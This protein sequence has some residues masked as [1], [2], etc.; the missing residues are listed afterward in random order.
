M[1]A[2]EFTTVTCATQTL[3]GGTATPSIAS[4]CATGSATVAAT[5]YTFGQGTT[6]QWESATDAAFTTGVAAIGTA[7]ANYADLATGTLSA[8]TYYRLKVICNGGA[9]AYSTV[10]GVIKN[11]PA[12]TTA[13][14]TATICAGASTSLTANGSSTYAW[15]PATGL[16]ATTGANVTATPTAT[17][18]YT[19]TGTDA[20]GCTSTATVTVTVNGYPSAISI[21]L[22]M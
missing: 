2:D 3:T 6:F 1:G 9:N 22:T 18:T 4:F 19:V 11:T 16:S 14:G 5:G 17:T 10:A 15:A 12:V 7:S 20:N 13:S 8:S 21:V